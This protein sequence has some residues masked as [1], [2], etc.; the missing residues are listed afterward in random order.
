MLDKKSKQLF[1]GENR[2]LGILLIA[3][4][5]SKHILIDVPFNGVALV[6]KEKIKKQSRHK[7]FIITYH[8]YRNILDIA[9]RK[10]VLHNGGTKEIQDKNELKY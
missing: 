3:Y 5:D 4:S 6:Y 10:V 2:I 8:D 9:T 1:G 7:G